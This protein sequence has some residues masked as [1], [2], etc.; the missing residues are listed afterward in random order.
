MKKVLIS[1][2]SDSKSM[3]D[4]LTGIFDY[5]NRRS[6][7]EMKIVSDPLGATT[8]GLTVKT[9]DTAIRSGTRGFIT[10]MDLRTP[11]FGRLIECGLPLVLNNTPPDWTPPTGSPIV[12]LRNDDLE[13][14][15][16]G[17]RYLHSKGNLQSYGYIPSAQKCFWSTFRHRGFRLELARW[18]QIPRVFLRSRGS[19]ADWLLALPKPAAIFAVTDSE[20]VNVIEVCRHLGLRIPEQIAL[21]GVDNDELYCRSSNPQISSIQPDHVEMGRRAAAELEQLMRHRLRHREIFIRPLQLIE[22]E[23][24]R[25][26]PPAGHLIRSALAYIDDNFQYGITVKDVAAHLRVSMP[27]L[28][29]RF[30]T[31]HGRS[32]R[33][34]I[35][36][37]RFNAA[38]RLL[39]QTNKPISQIA[40]ES[41]FASVCRFS[42][43]FR[44]RFGVSPE[45]WRTAGQLDSD[46]VGKAYPNRSTRRLS[47]RT[48]PP[49]TSPISRS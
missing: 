31:I 36:D 6:D 22:R 15:R 39:K 28:R 18:G 25:T 3:R 20:A 35:L 23:S 44:E 29:L 9:I 7:W 42:H 37:H 33:D 26:I 5:A 21:L 10:G 47:K 19:L 24:T 1:L 38:K 17:A 2:S 34:V 48:L 32:V 30:R 46:S 16:Q 27:L 8:G 12:V 4:C 13:V 11:G 41:G 49:A 14:G 43:F 45:T 40:V